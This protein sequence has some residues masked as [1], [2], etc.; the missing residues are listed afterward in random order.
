MSFP[1]A[2]S[3]SPPPAAH[4]DALKLRVAA[5]IAPVRWRRALDR[6]SNEIQAG[7][8]W[9]EATASPAW[10]PDANLRA[11]VETAMHSGH[12]A[13]LTMNLLQRHAA[14]AASWREL[15]TALTYPAVLLVLAL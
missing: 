9:Q 4:I 8:S 13:D 2:S 1:S 5:K 14:A 11:L 10:R 12:P 6:L 15:W 3:V 7:K